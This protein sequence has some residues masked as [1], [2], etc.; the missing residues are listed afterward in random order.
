[1]MGSLG[2]WGWLAL[3]FGLIAVEILLIPGGFPLWIGLAALAMGGITALVTMGWEAELIL[4]GLLSVVASVIAWKL[5]YQRSR[6]DAAD[7]LHDRVEQLIGRTFTLEEAISGG[8]GRVRIDDTS[9][10][11]SGADQPEGAKVK[12]VGVD[13]GTLKVEKAI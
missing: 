2:L 8:F 1:M 10:R 9:W 7:G 11:V 12:V 6:A 3:G 4:F 5:H 13:G